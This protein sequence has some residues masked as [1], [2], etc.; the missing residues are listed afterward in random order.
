MEEKT[1][2]EMSKGILALRNEKRDMTER[3]I[4]ARKIK[5]KNSWRSSERETQKRR[6]RNNGKRERQG[7]GIRKGSGKDVER[8]R[9]DGKKKSTKKTEGKKYRYFQNKK[10]RREKN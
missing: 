5:G 1:Y 7:G 10:E 3:K 4:N 8:K 9:N 6:R 2:S